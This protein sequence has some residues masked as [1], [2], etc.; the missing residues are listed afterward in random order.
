LVYFIA[1]WYIFVVIGYIFSQ[2]GMLYL[3]KSDNPA[4]DVCIKSTSGRRGDRRTRTCNLQL[5]LP[6]RSKLV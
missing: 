4:E 5:R 1:I 6:R 3:E 2:F